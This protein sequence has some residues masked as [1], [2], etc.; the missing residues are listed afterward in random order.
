MEDMEPRLFSFLK[1]R[2]NSFV[3]WDLVRFFHE[4]PNT[5]DTVDNVSRYAGRNPVSIE[6]E[7]IELAEAGVFHR[8]MVGEMAVYSLVTDQEMRDLIEEFVLACDD[9]RFR[10]KVIYHILRNMER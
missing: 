8:E 3:K 7:M 4:N 10:V 9:H 2:I 1:T 6:M 5:A